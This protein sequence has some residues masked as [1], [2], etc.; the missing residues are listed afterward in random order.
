MYK[1]TFKILFLMVVVLIVPFDAAM[2]QSPNISGTWKGTVAQNIGS[3]NY[4]VILTILSKGPDIQNVETNYPE[5]NCGGKLT[6][7]GASKGY[8]FYTETITRGGQNS[9]GS[10]IDGTVTV[11]SV[12]E[13]LAWGWFGS[14]DGQIYVAWSNL[15]RK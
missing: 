10:C 5:L 7:I 14:Y 11:A 15:V 3:T 8:I 13:K 4:T 2:A 12:G 9:G 6:R 1:S